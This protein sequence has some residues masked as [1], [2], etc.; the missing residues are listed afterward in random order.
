M[1]TGRLASLYTFQRDNANADGV[2]PANI[3]VPRQKPAAE[4]GYKINNV[5]HMPINTTPL[6][7][8]CGC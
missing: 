5:T 4:G 8:P 6:S 3:A 1:L 7:K 2:V